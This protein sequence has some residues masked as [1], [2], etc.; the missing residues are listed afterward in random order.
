MELTLDTIFGMAWKR[1]GIITSILGDLQGRFIL[2]VF[3]FTILAPFGLASRFLSDPM[4]F[5]KAENRVPAWRDRAPAGASLED[6][7]SQG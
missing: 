3:Y 7:R 6:A 5:R 1:M 2:T 4:F